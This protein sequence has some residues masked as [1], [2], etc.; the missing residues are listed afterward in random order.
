MLDPRDLPDTPIDFRQYAK[1]LFAS[2]DLGESLENALDT[3]V[4]S[5]AITFGGEALPRPLDGPRSRVAV[6]RLVEMGVL[7]AE[8]AAADPAVFLRPEEEAALEA[9]V[10]LRD[11]PA[12]LIRQDSFP[13]PPERWTKLDTQFRADISGRIPCVGRIEERPAEMVGTGFMVAEDLVMT[14]KHV[15]GLFADPPPTNGP[16]VILRS[17]RPVIDFKVEHGEAG[18]RVFAITEVVDVHPKLDIALVRIDKKAIEPAGALP[19]PPVQLASQ[20]PDTSQRL[21][22][23]AVG[24]P[25]TDNENV[26]PPAV[27]DAIYEGILKVKRLQPG[28]FGAMFEGYNAFSHDCSTLGGN[29]GSCIVDIQT[30]RV[31]GLHFQGK[32]R[33]ANYAIALWELKCDR[34]FT[35]RG[36]SFG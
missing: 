32:Y 21:D 30:N 19:P 26:T 3:E 6:A 20:G 4:R 10:R 24:Y 18:K 34:L 29:S 31:I 23:Y 36:L 12:L 27:L 25:W 14:N 11:R 22:L 2:E 9:V 5:R 16:W 15:V 7:A 28:E 13:T 8:K 1:G 33:Q 35:N 17:R